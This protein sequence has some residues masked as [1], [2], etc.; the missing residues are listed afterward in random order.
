MDDAVHLQRAGATVLVYRCDDPTCPASLKYIAH[1]VQHGQLQV[2]M[3][4]GPTQE[5]GEVLMRFLAD[6]IGRTGASRRDPAKARAALAAKRASGGAANPSTVP[7]GGGLSPI[8]AASHSSHPLAQER[9]E[10]QQ[11]RLDLKE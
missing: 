11:A 9:E 2:A 3:R 1:W 8:G 4:P 6:Q 7:G 5:C 10:P